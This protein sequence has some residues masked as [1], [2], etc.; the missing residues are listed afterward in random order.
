M[1]REHIPGQQQAVFTALVDPMRRSLLLHLAKQSPKT[2]TELAHD[3]PIMRQGILKHLTVLEAAD[4]VV[5]RQQGRD[6]RYMLRPE[7]L[8]ELEQWIKDV[9]ALWDKRLSR[10][11]TWLEDEQD[12]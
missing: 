10:L 6:K 4:L 11:K 3:Y 5:V 1:I 12:Q 9:G 7:P 2:A 8:T